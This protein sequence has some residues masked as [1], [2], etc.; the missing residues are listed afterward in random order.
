MDICHPSHREINVLRIVNQWAQ[1]LKVPNDNVNN[2]LR[3]TLGDLKS[4]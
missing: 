4:I 3:N 2:K 1:Y